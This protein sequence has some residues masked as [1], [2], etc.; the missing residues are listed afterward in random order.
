MICIG[1]GLWLNSQSQPA[2]LVTT[3]AYRQTLVFESEVLSSDSAV[4]LEDG[5]VL[6]IFFNEEQRNSICGGTMTWA[7][8]NAVNAL[9]VYNNTLIDSK[10]YAEENVYFKIWKKSRNC[11]LDSVKGYFRTYSDTSET[12]TARDTL[13]VLELSG[14]K[15]FHAGYADTRLCSN[16]GIVRP[17]TAPAGYNLLYSSSSF[18]VD[19]ATGEINLAG[20]FSGTLEIKF[21]T[22]YCLASSSQT[23]VIAPAPDVSLPAEM[24]LC[25]GTELR[26]ELDPYITQVPTASDSAWISSVSEAVRVSED[27]FDYKVRLENSYCEATR[28]IRVNRLPK[29]V[30]LSA[31]EDLCDSV[32][33]HLA[34]EE[35]NMEWSTASMPA[36]VPLDG[37]KRTITFTSDEQLTLKLTGTNECSSS[38][39]IDVRVRKM[40]ISTFD[41]E[42]I[43][44]DC[45]KPGKINL[46]DSHV[47]NHE[48]PVEL[49]LENL[50]TGE[51]LPYDGLLKE[52]RY[53]VF[54][55]DERNCIARWPQEMVILKDCLNDDP[56]FSP[57]SDGR[58]DDFFIPYEGIVTIYN[59]NGRLIHRFTGPAYWDGTDDR[60]VKLPLGIYLMVTGQE[61][62]TITILR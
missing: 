57:N 49:R 9:T 28:T 35:G 46:R 47:I 8:N 14:G 43:N 20:S 50:L 36:A 29:P 60:G 10:T 54:A 17:K 13:K 11:I 5:D 62:K 16:E 2:W 31:T 33:I 61:A 30:F 6:G 23:L 56:V 51:T 40:E 12:I 3:D 55:R 38:D 59:K 26:S 15:P 45:Y 42:E 48:G 24:R 44:A 1:L 21:A 19:G 58:D 39:K 27:T 37:D 52:G 18:P 4:F 53:R 7:H 32:R 22:D 25:E 41:A 34:Y